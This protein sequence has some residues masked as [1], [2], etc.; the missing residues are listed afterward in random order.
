[1]LTANG[2]PL[3][4]APKPLGRGGQGEVFEVLSD[5]AMVC[6]VYFGPTLAKEPTLPDRLAA[7]VHSKPGGRTD[8]SGHLLLGWPEAAVQ[9]NGRFAG[10]LMPKV[11]MR[12]TVELHRVTNPSD[13]RRAG[14]W[15]KG[16]TWQ[17]LV[18][19]AANL[20]HATGVLHNSGTV[21][22][23]FNLK[24]V[25]VSDRALVTLID[26]DSMQ[27]TDVA[28]G[29]RFFCPVGMAEFQ[30]PELRNADLSRTVRHPSSDHYALAIHLH[31]LLLEGEHPFRGVWQGVGDKPGVPLLARDGVWS[32]K[33]GG[34][35]KPRPAAI[36]AELLLPDGVREMFRRAF[37]D[38][39]ADPDQR[40]SAAEWHS[41]LAELDDRLQACSVVPDHW[42]DGDQKA[43]PWCADEKA[44]Q[45][46]RPLPPVQSGLGPR[47]QP[48]PAAAV[49]QWSSRQRNNSRFVLGAVFVAALVA[50]I[51][52]GRALGESD[53]RGAIGPVIAPTG[54]NPATVTATTAEAQTQAPPTTTG[55]PET[56]ASTLHT[57]LAGSARDRKSVLA[58]V[59]DVKACGSLARDA[60]TF[61]TAQNH[62][63]TLSD[64]IAAMD[65]SA[66][67]DGVRMQTDLTQAL[68]ISAQADEKFAEWADAMQS[69]CNRKAAEGSPLYAS[70]METSRTANAHKQTF[71]ELWN[72]VCRQ[73]GWPELVE[74]DV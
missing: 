28:T 60:T 7:M 42:Y 70:A 32:G 74:T 57:Y 13:R 36:K 10:F 41:A 26:C 63:S 66:L 68:S 39:A 54:A 20:A 12:N 4:L 51:L 55:D 11:D 21:I 3:R 58:A 34:L 14:G 45:T 23:D 50:V 65:L 27:V 1:M 48:P 67:D 8:S 44:R 19:T 5:P 17:Y 2:R 73:N 47:I 25:L 40:P 37:E 22:G 38:G 59:N 49:T 6:K 52:G 64:Q 46:Q 35:L 15:I 24:N 9:D 61:R 16:F 29:K 33:T 71:I 56:Q 43:C 18:R 62:R 30:P 31:Q 69:N 72:P 53:G